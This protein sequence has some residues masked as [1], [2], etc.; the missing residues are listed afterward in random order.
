MNSEEAESIKEFFSKD[1]SNVE[2]KDIISSSDD[3]S[4]DETSSQQLY[5]NAEEWSCED[6]LDPGWEK[7]QRRTFAA[8]CN[9]HLR[10]VG[11]NIE[12]VDVDFR[13]GVKL[14]LLLEVISCE[15]LGK[16]DRGNMRFHKIANVN[17]AL[18]F[19]KRK[20]IRLASI[21][22]EEIVDGNV[23]MT[24][25]MI[26]TIILRFHIQDISVDDSSA[27]EGLLLWCQRET[28]TYSNVDVKN[29]DKSWK[30]G[31]AFCA[32][33]HKH[34]PEILPQFY[35]L[36]KEDPFTNLNL[37]FDIAEKHLDIPKMLDAEYLVNNPKPDERAVM[38]YLSS[39]YHCF[40]E[41][42]LNNNNSE[43]L[44]KVNDNGS[45]KNDTDENLMNENSAAKIIDDFN[46]LNLNP[47]SSVH[48]KT[49]QKDYLKSTGE[50]FDINKKTNS[51][52]INKKTTAQEE[53]KKQETLEKKNALTRECKICCENFDE[54]RFECVLL[55]GHRFCKI[56]IQ[57]MPQKFCPVCR[58][59]YRPE[60]A[61]KLF[62]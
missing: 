9:S 42:N 54:I 1:F 27:K 57:E 30:D 44:T 26:W 60:Q 15:R 10:N 38:T 36:K 5:S 61:I 28:S 34:R 23:K 22:A 52:M 32:L 35:D 20:G 31:L 49:I 17:K 8:W 47:D 39:L 48:P 58:K 56:C 3:E 7:Q 11:T 50:S 37:A 59:G 51:G 18:D 40:N 25:G 62:D 33:I 2:I 41:S 19:L 53:F 29:I 55:C 14:M 12:A 45:K 24:L 16:P 4:S 13:D 46:E 21:G 43:N 6:N